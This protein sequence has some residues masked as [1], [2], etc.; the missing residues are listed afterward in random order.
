MKHS[1]AETDRTIASIADIPPLLATSVVRGSVQG[2]SHGG[3]F[4]I[5]PASRS[6]DQVLDWNTA[7]IDWAGRGWDRGL[8]GV[9]FYGGEVYIAASDELFVFDQRFQKLR[10]YRSR[11]LKHCHEIAVY[12]NIL[13]LTSTG[14]DSIL[15]FNLD[16]ERFIWGMQVS[17]A[18]GTWQGQRFDP[19]S[20]AGPRP[21]NLFHINNVVCDS[22]RFTFSGLR[23][24]GIVAM[25]SEMRLRLTVELPA[26]VH[27]ARLVDDGVLFNDTAA[28]YLRFVTRDGAEKHFPFPSYDPAEI[29]FAGID[30]SKTASQG[31]GR[32]LCLINDRLVAAGSSPSTVSVFDLAT[33]QRVFAVNFSMDIR[34]AIH[35]LE[36]W[37]YALPG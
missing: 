17:E 3:V 7:D 24:H 10:S 36:V 26:G 18:D 25:G 12:E 15:A 6:V 22:Q 1:S 34:N 29:E 8:R 13:Y 20:N 16:E 5:D 14:F 4:L 31:F 19:Q 30:D 9:A 32:G 35:G 23:T 33:A 21:Q 37:P 28:K 27:N 11:Y 2:Q